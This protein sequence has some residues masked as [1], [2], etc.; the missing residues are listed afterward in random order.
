[1]IKWEYRQINLDTSA[2][3]NA[4]NEEKLNKFGERGW[5]VCGGWY[6]TVIL[7]RKKEDW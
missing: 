3:S 6:D 2:G 5:E 7:K 4:R 1:M